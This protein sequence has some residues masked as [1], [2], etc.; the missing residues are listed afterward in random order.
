MRF[1]YV[2]AYEIDGKVT[3]EFPTTTLLEKA[4]PVLETLPGWKCD[5]RGIKTLRRSSGKLQEVH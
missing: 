1:R 3:T 4:K 5:I 2:L